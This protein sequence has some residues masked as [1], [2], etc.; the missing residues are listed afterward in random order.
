VTIAALLKHAELF[1][2]EC[3]YETAC[4]N[5]FSETELVL[6][7]VDLD[8][9][10]ARRKNGRF[11]VGKRRRRSPG[12]TAEVVS[13]LREHGLVVPAIADRLGVSDAYVRRILGQSRTAEQG[14]ANPY[15]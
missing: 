3:V 15:G 11:T 14:A 2:A 5:G 12:E 9:I 1:G 4:Q 10:E 6:L 7:R 8:A 13:L